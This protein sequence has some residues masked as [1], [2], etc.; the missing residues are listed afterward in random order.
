MLKTWL[1]HPL[2]RGLNLDDPQTTCLRSQIV[3]GKPFLRKV[4]EEWYHDIIQSLP[5]GGGVIIELGSGGGFLNDLIPGLITSEV[6]MCP[7]V[8]A[9][10][11][12]LQ[13]P[14]EDASLRAIVMTNVF[15]HLS[16]PRRFFSEAA[17]CVRPGGTIVMIE[18][19]VTAWS[20]FVYG[21]LHH[22]PF[23][24]ETETW[25]FPAA[26]PLSGAN[27]AL[28]WIV[29]ERDRA[30]FSEEFP[31]WRVR[32]IEPMMPFLY[33]LSGGVSTRALMPEWTYGCWC[34][35]ENLVKPWMPQLGMFARVV[36]RRE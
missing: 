32:L 1:T 33:L 22:E 3:R 15:H 35:L 6:F 23:E 14:F 28:P 30:R 36:L 8:K 18:P 27:G 11:D 25:E 29:F 7:G 5:D 16:Q 17:R 13:L 26:G 19:W 4:Y 2:T 20:R 12:A 21:R 9:V 10:L 24:P 31:Q 34:W